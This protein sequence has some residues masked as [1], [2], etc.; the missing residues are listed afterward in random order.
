MSEWLLVNSQIKEE[1]L[2]NTITV[3]FNRGGE[4]IHVGEVLTIYMPLTGVSEIP[5]TQNPPKNDGKQGVKPN[6]EPKY[7]ASTAGN[8]QLV[9]VYEMETISCIGLRSKTM[10]GVKEKWVFPSRGNK[11]VRQIQFAFRVYTPP[12][13][14]WSYAFK[15]YSKV[16]ITE[17]QL[18]QTLSDI[19]AWCNSKISISQYQQSPCHDIILRVMPLIQLAKPTDQIP[20]VSPN[21]TYTELAILI[22]LSSQPLFL[23]SNPAGD[24][25]R[26]IHSVFKDELDEQIRKSVIKDELNIYDIPTRVRSICP[27]GSQT[28][29]PP[30]LLKSLAHL[31]NYTL[32]KSSILLSNSSAYQLTKW[33]PICHPCPPG[34]APRTPYA[35]D[36]CHLCPKGY[37]LGETDYPSSGGCLQCPTGFTTDN[38]GATSVRECH[39]EGGAVT[40]L[41]IGFFLNIW[42]EFEQVVVGTMGE[43][44]HTRAIGQVHESYWAW[45]GKISLSLWIV[46]S[47]FIMVTLW[48]SSLAIYRIHLYIKLHK[49][50]REQFRL[51]LK[52][53]LIGQI[54]LVIRIKQQ[55][56]A[57]VI[58][59]DVKFG[60]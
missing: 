51:L 4:V 30:P 2:A 47:L 36:G 27:P 17:K 10:I 12:T 28:Y 38:L 37:Y 23:L 50:Y 9:F 24:H 46:V 21:S 53:A 52:S 39:L 33:S 15:S 43:E 41:I 57:S 14:I 11:I 59:F 25:F 42:R 40:R 7:R 54:N 19:K 13:I 22:D 49:M 6:L 16:I 8:K 1:S 56:K 34:H 60:N 3:W 44:T 20:F 55:I 48:I 5:M 35:F 31:G 29:H 26:Y 32:N 45:K 58:P 18:T